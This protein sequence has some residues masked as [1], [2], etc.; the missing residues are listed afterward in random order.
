MLRLRYFRCVWALRT[1]ASIRCVSATFFLFLVLTQLTGCGTTRMSDTLRTGTE[2]ILLSAAIDRC[3]S[4]MDFSELSGKDVYFD[5][6]YLRGVSDEGYIVST[7]RQRLLAEGVFLKSVRDEATYVVEARAGAVGTNRQDVLIGIP[8][9]SLPT[10]A[11]TAGIPSVI[12]EIPFAKKTHQKGVAK[13]AVFAYNQTTGQAL[14]QSGATPITADARDTW[15]F[16]TGPF[17]RGSIYAGASFAG[18]RVP[19]WN[20]D[21]AIASRPPAKGIPVNVAQTFDED[22]DVVPPSPKLLAEKKAENKATPALFTPAVPPSQPQPGRAPSPI[23]SPSTA[24]AAATG[25]SAS[26]M[27]NITGGQ[28]SN[29]SSG[30]NAAAASAGLLIF[31][32]STKPV[33]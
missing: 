33:E 22:P 27:F 26:S 12:P 10:G 32:N 3:I 11:L 19:G 7:I 6:Q 16:G 13:I 25:F 2:Q 20:T 8:Q 28:P 18:Q 9:T 17:Q 31:K 29:G 24:P 14:W 21:K 15:I 23:P 30:G 1:R 4:E 5:P